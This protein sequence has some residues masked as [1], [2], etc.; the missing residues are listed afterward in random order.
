MIRIEN[1]RTSLNFNLS[2][3]P[4]LICQKLNIPSSRLDQWQIVKRAIDA[5]KKKRI[6]IVFTVDVSFKHEQVFLKSYTFPPNLKVKHVEPF[7]FNISKIVGK[8]KHQPV[9]VGSGPCGLFA[10]LVLAEA[11]F[12]PVILERGKSVADRT[13]DVNRF[14]QSG[15]LDSE[16]NI[17][18]G[19][20]GAG[21]FSDGKLY[22]LIKDPRTRLVFDTLVQAGAPVEIAYDAKPH[23]GTDNLRK[24]IPAIRQRITNAGGEFRFSSKLT[25]FASDGST[26]QSIQINESENIE[27]DTLVLAIGHSARDTVEMLHQQGLHMKQ[28]AFSIGVR[29]EHKRKWIDFAQFGEQAGHPNLGAGKYKLSI[30]LENNRGVYT[31]CMCPGGTVVPAASE[32]G[33]LVTNGMSEHAQNGI[34]SNS[35]VLVSVFPSDFESDHPLA[36]I[37]FQR[38]WEALAFELGGSN[39]HAPVQRFDD[40]MHGK[41][42]TKFGKVDPSYLPGT[43]FAPLQ[44]CLPE[45]VTESLK[46]GIY[47]LNRKLKGF[48]HPDTLL[49]GVETRSSAPYRIPRDEE[50]QSN[51]RGI[52]PVGEGAGHAGGIVSSAV[53]GIKIAEAIIELSQ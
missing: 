9:I 3:L 16:S 44:E 37:A 12:N 10:G 29:I 2:E 6:E 40:F 28:K 49:T 52:Y 42:S 1:I 33:H 14:M 17:Q 21:T 41:T 30:H 27:T 24:I 45:F 15:E 48:A 46:A 38:K 47:Y 22:T 35:G 7:V 11:G 53:D 26:L 36:G 8:P 5:R 50:F 39:Y 34:N 25:D 31:F 19:E 18:F 20:G 13:K 51:I 4:D 23:I 32:A 43:T